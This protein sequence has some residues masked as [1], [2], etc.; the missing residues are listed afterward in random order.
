MVAGERI[1]AGTPIVE[2]TAENNAGT[3]IPNIGG[4]NG[5]LTNAVVDQISA[6]AK[7]R[8]NYNTG[9]ILNNSQ[10]SDDRLTARIDANLSDTQRASLTYLYTKDSIRYNQNTTVT[11]PGLGLESNGYTGSNRLHTGVFQLNSDWSDEFS[12]EFR[13]F[14]KDYKRGQDPVLGRGFAQFQVCAAPDSDRSNP[15]SAGSNASTTCAP[16]YASIYFGPDI[17]RQSNALTSRTYGGLLQ[18]R[19]NRDNHDLRIFADFQDTKIVNV[20][21][22]RSAGDYYF[23]SIADFQAGNAQRLRYQNAVP[24]LNPIDAAAR[25]RYQSYAFGIQDNWRITDWFSLDYGIRYDVYGGHSRPAFNQNFFNRLG[26]ANT[27]YISGRGIAQPRIGFELRPTKDLSVRGG[28]GIFS[29]G[30]PDVYIS[31]S[32][33]NTGFL[34]NTIDIRQN[35][36]GSYAGTGLP[37]GVG[38]AALTNV[39]GTQIPGS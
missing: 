8:Y 5:L 20:F 12:T 14:Y 21:L 37:A 34:S 36:D 6:I 24:S 3:V 35:N 26:Y 30:S 7:S 19:L 39:N 23:D 25:F 13:A 9:G 17:S 33:S 15:G 27:A 16:G 29:G 31:N 18:G 22:Q 10:D 38:A 1:R 32:F 4:A 28:V 11:G 2:G